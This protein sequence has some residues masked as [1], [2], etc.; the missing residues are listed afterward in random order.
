LQK[1]FFRQGS[2]ELRHSMALARH[3]CPQARFRTIGAQSIALPPQAILGSM[4]FNL[5]FDLV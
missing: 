5:R 2:K 4:E 3:C 1:Y